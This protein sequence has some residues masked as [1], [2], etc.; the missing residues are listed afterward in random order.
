MVGGPI[1]YGST[2]E[3]LAAFSWVANEDHGYTLYDHVDGYGNCM[4]GSG[5]SDQQVVI[6]NFAPE[7]MA[8][9]GCDVNAGIQ[10][11]AKNYGPDFY[12]I[13][14][15]QIKD[16]TSL[17]EHINKLLEY[18]EPSFGAANGG[19]VQVKED[20]V[21]I[22][23]GP[24]TLNAYKVNDI[25]AVNGKGER[26]DIDFRVYEGNTPVATGYPDLKGGREFYVVIN[27]ERNQGRWQTG[28]IKVTSQ[29][30]TGE[31]FGTFP[32][33][34]IWKFISSPGGNSYP[35]QHMIT[36]QKGTKSDGEPRDLS[37]DVQRGSTTIIIQKYG[38]KEDGTA[39]L[40][41]GLLGGAKFRIFNET[42]RQYVAIPRAYLTAQTNSKFL[43]PTINPDDGTHGY[44]PSTGTYTLDFY[45]PENSK[46]DD[47][48][49]F[50]TKPGMPIILTNLAE[51][52]YTIEEVVPPAGY[53]SAENVVDGVQTF[54]IPDNGG[55]SRDF[56]NKKKPG[57]RINKYGVND[58]GEIDNEAGILEGARFIIRKTDG[59]K[60]QYVQHDDG[61][62]WQINNSS[63]DVKED[64]YIDEDKMDKED[65]KRDSRFTFTNI[66]GQSLQLFG[67]KDGEYEVEEVIPPDGYYLS[68]EEEG[69]KV[70]IKIPDQ[71]NQS[72]DFKNKKA[73][74]NRIRINKYGLKDNGEV[75][76]E[77]GILEGARFIIRKIDGEKVQYIKH[78]DGYNWNENNSTYRV[79]EEDY[80]DEDKMDKEDLKRD[81]HFTFTNIGG[82]SLQIL[83][84]KDGKYEIE[85]VI[86]PT[87]YELSTNGD[88][89]GNIATVQIPEQADQD[90]NFHNPKVGSNRITINKY[91][92]TSTGTANTEVRLGGAKL[93]IKFR[94]KGEST[95][96]QYLIP[97]NSTTTDGAV[98]Y[99]VT[100][101]NYKDIQGTDANSA[102]FTTVEGKKI[103]FE[104]L[105]DGDY[106]VEEIEAPQGYVEDGITHEFSIPKDYGNHYDIINNRDSTI[107]IRKHGYDSYKDITDN[108]SM[109]WWTCGSSTVTEPGPSVASGKNYD[110]SDP[111]RLYRI[112]GISADRE[113]KLNEIAATIHR[114]VFDEGWTYGGV[115]SAAG[116]VFNS[117]WEHRAYANAHPEAKVIDCSTYVDYI[118]TDFR[119]TYPDAQGVKLPSRWCPSLWGTG[120]GDEGHPCPM[121]EASGGLFED[122]TNLGLD[123]LQQGDFI[124]WEGHIQMFAYY[125]GG[126]TH[127]EYQNLVE[128]LPGAGFTIKNSS[129]GEYVKVPANSSNSEYKIGR[130]DYVKVSEV[131]DVTSESSGVLFVTQA[132]KGLKFNGLKAGV[133]KVEEVIP[134]TG[135]SLSE[136]G[137]GGTNIQTFVVPSD[138]DVTELNF[139]NPKDIPQDDLIFKKYDED[140][141]NAGS[142]VGLAG[143]KFE[144]H[145]KAGAVE[146]PE[147][148]CG[149]CGSDTLHRWC[150]RGPS[151][152]HTG[153]TSWTDANGGTHTSTYTYYTYTPDEAAWN[154]I[155]AS[156]DAA[157]DE[158]I[159][160]YEK[161]EAAIKAI[162]PVTTD[163]K[164]EAKLTALR[165]RNDDKRGLYYM[166]E[167]SVGSNPYYNIDSTP[168]DIDYLVESNEIIRTNKRKRVDL[169]GM[170]WEDLPTGKEYS[171]ANGFKEEDEP[172]L[173]PIEIKLKNGN[174]TIGKAVLTDNGRYRLRIGGEDGADLQYLSDPNTYVE[175]TYNGMKYQSTY[176][177]GTGGKLSD[178]VLNADNGTKALETIDN[179]N[180]FNARYTTITSG[181]NATTTNTNKAESDGTEICY[182][183]D[184]QQYKST[185]RY[186]GSVSG[187]FSRDE[188]ESEPTGDAVYTVS[189][190]PG[191]NQ[192]PE[193]DQEGVNPNDDGGADNCH[194][195]TNKQGGSKYQ[196]Q[197]DTNT[198]GYSISQHYSNDIVKNGGNTIRNVN[199]GLYRREHPDISIVSDIY[200][201]M[202]GSNT[203]VDGQRQEKW[204]TYGEKTKDENLEGLFNDNSI[205][206][207]FENNTKLGSY[208]RE[209][210]PSEV[211]A[212]Y[213]KEFEVKVVYKTIIRNES[214][215]LYMQPTEMISNYD[216]DY[217]SIDNVSETPWD[218]NSTPAVNVVWQK[219]ASHM[220]QNSTH[221]ASGN[222][223]SAYG[224]IDARIPSIDSG[225]NNSITIYTQ[226]TFGRDQAWAMYDPSSEGRVPF[227]SHIEVNAYTTTKPNQQRGLQET[228]A[229]VDVDS[230]VG[231]S[232]P[233]NLSTYEDDNDDAPVFELVRQANRT[234][235][236]TVFKD[237]ITTSDGP[238]G[239]YKA[240]GINDGDTPLKGVQVELVE[241]DND[242]NEK[243]WQPGESRDT[244]TQPEGGAQTNT[245]V[246]NVNGNEFK[247]ERNDGTTKVELDPSPD[248]VNATNQALVVTGDDGK[249]TF[250]GFIPGRYIIKYTWGGRSSIVPVNV[251]GTDEYLYP[252]Q[253]KSTVFVDKA[254]YD[255]YV[256][257]GNAPSRWLLEQVSHKDY[258]GKSN[259][260]DD[261]GERYDI[262]SQMLVVD[263][264]DG[265]KS[266]G[267]V[268]GD[269]IDIDEKG[270]IM[271]SRTPA[272]EVGV[273][274]L[275]KET[276]NGSEINTNGLNNKTGNPQQNLEV[277]GLDFG[278]CERPKMDMSL[279]KRIE[280]IKITFAN[281]QPFVDATVKDD[282][283]LDGLYPNSIYNKPQK[284]DPSNLTT[285]I[286]IFK[287]EMDQEVMQGATLEITYKYTIANN[288]NIDYVLSEN[289]I[290]PDASNSYK[291]K[292]FKDDNVYY[293]FG[294]TDN[295][296]ENPVEIQPTIIVDY[297][298]NKMN[299]LK[300]KDTNGDGSIDS[301]EGDE[302]APL[303]NTY[304][305]KIT[306]DTEREDRITKYLFDFRQPYL[307]DKNRGNYEDYTDNKSTTNPPNFE[308]PSVRMPLLSRYYWTIV[309]DQN[310]DASED[311]ISLT[312]GASEV[313]KLVASK[314]LSD[315]DK[316]LEYYNTAEI[317]QLTKT[318]GGEPEKII[319]GDSLPLEE[320]QQD[321]YQPTTKTIVEGDGETAAQMTITAPTG[322]IYNNYERGVWTIVALVGLSIIGIGTAIIRR[323]VLVVDEKKNTSAEK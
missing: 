42:T 99:R 232:V 236:G 208:K 241:V 211:K 10:A 34:K 272:F 167:T 26:L 170:I 196:I 202:V 129:T 76:E 257:A 205:G 292:D 3:A 189:K 184:S 240:D 97:A 316:D 193:T 2:P 313:R 225:E 28:N 301:S 56:H 310:A 136:N 44:D 33:A 306:D 203:E 92:G 139:L 279:E 288:S 298:D 182:N 61:Y 190:M 124:L 41:T 268:Y 294:I 32:E 118:L 71:L 303:E 101:S 172:L 111:F 4:M 100:D 16:A 148:R 304:W 113:A 104:N 259:A 141:L 29:V 323:I 210:A 220:K 58:N 142:R 74:D 84:L 105:K 46:N 50:E 38:L 128:D 119:A 271:H 209:V 278:I 168:F 79:K 255:S 177:A 107:V 115:G 221:N 265:T 261:M 43:D 180:N 49:M 191:A 137:D 54:N 134:P 66:S 81:S 20:N 197:A 263:G 248:D 153:T 67:L 9:T 88:G 206:V 108:R 187:S 86:P 144:I 160:Q 145:Q 312:A 60:V 130:K 276:D 218:E 219:G 87:D 96:T 251:S 37:I 285:P 85:E 109:F 201:A 250:S 75:D 82:Q 223:Q 169:E 246:Q 260:V 224:K 122:I 161:R 36:F 300:G 244:G 138:A 146:Y 215:T 212:A 173:D 213:S 11:G 318:G 322:D 140:S 91:A 299:Y 228:Y 305:E 45:Q 24:L 237:A 270:T 143:F 317:I 69:N 127:R 55:E 8:I 256:N 123:N 194:Y 204:Y 93:L 247:N 235:S 1:P 17:D 320:V 147:L 12:P 80:I 178:A 59:E 230:A 117:F 307:F 311:V 319:P 102:V 183:K 30:Q 149:L 282:G 135:Y 125:Q 70:K 154:A 57:I 35:H 166:I 103:D 19:E 222:Y 287:S 233:D 94:P 262:D 286:G 158:A 195:I 98:T 133:Y 6:W 18:R 132:G 231:N 48:V 252:E 22:L 171:S 175:F 192:D 52:N 245:S 267:N 114:I 73:K 89:K 266:T 185:I 186:E 151:E 110:F 315:T 242:G 216:T 47:V 176:I 243:L 321:V 309:R 157:V 121:G 5:P 106:A 284:L 78:D 297:L 95:Y 53:E 289:E 229:G 275:D 200:M 291:F 164:G 239:E 21:E 226:Y 62:N 112:R 281:G 207:R 188:I 163:K 249:Y 179:R 253:Y 181:P 64:D 90:F 254:R 174:K 238:G 277:G 25:L 296:R 83:G 198:G 234:I 295:I 217:V 162:S 152:R 126:G 51:G 7:V 39:D 302:G 77:K 23:I 159:K 120:I 269:Y 227:Y 214:T 72:F 14:I 63:Y 15:Q 308:D 274:A 65:L 68:T 165:T 293:K 13:R 199:L 273:E 131:S 31:C 40:D 116:V 155:A 27:K 264:T 290:S 280:R 283:T 150:R 258:E 156:H 314:L